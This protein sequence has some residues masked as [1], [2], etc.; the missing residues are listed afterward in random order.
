MTQYFN[1]SSAIDEATK[2]NKPHKMDI[3]G[4]GQTAKRILINKISTWPIQNIGIIQ[5]MLIKKCKDA[6]LEFIET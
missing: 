5:R 1:Y 3:D 2:C 4:E 6:N